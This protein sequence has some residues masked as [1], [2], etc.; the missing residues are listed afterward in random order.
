MSVRSLAL[1]SVLAFAVM[2]IAS[3]PIAAQTIATV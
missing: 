2:W 1:L 3:I